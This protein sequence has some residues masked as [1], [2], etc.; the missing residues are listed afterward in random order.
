[1]LDRRDKMEKT[2]LVGLRKYDRSEQQTVGEIL[3]HD[4][5]PTDANDRQRRVYYYYKYSGAQRP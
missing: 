1:M 2:D 4:D 5:V 3:L